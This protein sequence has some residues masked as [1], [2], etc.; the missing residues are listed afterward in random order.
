MNALERLRTAL[1]DRYVIQ[2]EIGRGGMAIAFLAHDRKYHRDVAIKVLKPEFTGSVPADRFLREIQFEAQLKHPYILPLFESGEAGG[3]LYYVMPHI[4]GQSLQARLKRDTQLRI[5][6]ALRI[7]A[8]VAEA[9]SHAHA[10]GLVHRDVKPGNILLDENH[11]LL[12]DFGFARAVVESSGESLSES[13]MV[14]GTPEYMSPEQ[15]SPGAKI[16][17][18]SDVYALGCVLYEMLAGEPPFTGPS[19]Q[20]VIARHMYDE[21]R[22]LRVVRPAVPEH[23]EEAI[24]VALAKV[25]ADRHA[26]A[27]EFVAALGPAGEARSSSSKARAARSR[28]R[29][30]TVVAA[31]VVILAGALGL[32]SL[33]LPTSA[34]LDSNKVVLFPLTERALQATDSGAGYDVA[35]MLSAALEH[36]QPLR[37][38]D[39]AAR[40]GEPAAISTA[41]R[42]ARELRRI[43]RGQRAGFYI[44]GAVVGGARDSTTVVLRLHSTAGDSIVQQESVGA[45]RDSA[46]PVQ[47]GLL[48]VSRLLPALVDPGRA[49]DLT[50]LS[51]RRAGATALWIQ[52]E[53]EYRRSRFRRALN[54]YQ[55]AIAEDSAMAFAAI[56]GAQAAS[57][58]DLGGE[59]LALVGVAIGRDS[60][61]Q[62]KHRAL[63]HGL[64][65]LWSG[66][67]DG[68]VAMLSQALKLDREWAEGHMALAEVYYHR[69]PAVSLP[70][71]SLAEAEFSRAAQLDSGFAPPLYHLTEITLRRG[72]VDEATALIDRFRAFAPDTLRTQQLLMAYTCVKN[73]PAATDWSSEV[74]RHPMVVLQAARVL[75]AGAAQPRCAE[76]ML[77][78]VLADRA[79][80]ELHWGAFTTLHGLVMAG[81]RYGELVPL[82]DS[83]SAGGLGRALAMYLVDDLAGAPVGVKAE[84]TEALWR[85]WYGKHY[86]GIS[87][88]TRWLLAAW[89]AHRGDTTRLKDLREA[90]RAEL[91]TA[92]L[93]VG[94]VL[95]AHLALARGDS[96]DAAHR[97]GALRIDL[98]PDL[99]EWGLV[100]PLPIERLRLAGL[101]L[102]RKDFAEAGRIAAVF[103]HPAPVAFLPFIPAVREVRRRAAQGLRPS[104]IATSH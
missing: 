30:V 53:R 10:H 102:A 52:G 99:L 49:V 6:E 27:A 13:G 50:A 36:A 17:Q 31:G 88:P 29:G 20:A 68:A 65:A 40:L 37:W 39:G 21:P 25:P 76:P 89:L 78:A 15:G 56:K 51:S 81:E 98:P 104:D 48:A 38:I 58:V 91:D 11:A 1:A 57:W 41:P 69:L 79:Q 45:A 92:S 19:F 87:L 32:G 77:K 54:F 96:A 59:A 97:F 24:R 72:K 23:V 28:R 100:E 64:Q 5:D 85:G 84:A 94:A 103:D 33:A 62:P 46:S 34:P 26:S 70:L 95:D 4:A 82:I 75:A 42:P 55:R 61:L 67:A 12:A 18:R 14:V 101:V 63:A 16:D 74:S 93:P 43:A 66:N 3:L 71:D 80:E 83:A 90:W 86:E 2:R 9:L 7:T 35:V 22:S 60:L 47:L 44:D 73:G 8:D